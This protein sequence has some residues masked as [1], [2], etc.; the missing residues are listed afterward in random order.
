M[1]DGSL[2]QKDRIS[3]SKSCSSHRFLFHMGVYI[4]HWALPS[5]HDIWRH[6]PNGCKYGQL[7]FCGRRLAGR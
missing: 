5:T 2:D 7:R 1:E 4:S 6:I 3:T